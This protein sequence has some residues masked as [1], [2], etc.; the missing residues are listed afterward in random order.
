MDNGRNQR[1][2][3]PGGVRPTGQVEIAAAERRRPSITS[4]L[5]TSI[6]AICLLVGPSAPAQGAVFGG[7][8]RKPYEKA[9]PAERA[10]LLNAIG[11]ISCF[12]G[13][14]GSGFLVDITEYV[15][16][17]PNFYVIA[18]TAQVLYDEAG[19][20]RGRC[21]YVPASAPGHYFEI[22]D[23]LAGTTR[24][25]GADSDN[26]AFARIEHLSGPHV[27]LRIAF[28]NTYDFGP[29]YHLELEVAGFV[30]AWGEVAVTSECSL[31][32]KSRYPALWKQGFGLAHM[33]IHDC[34]FMRSARGG[35]L[36]IRDRG[37][38]LVIAVNAGDTRSE[39]QTRLYGVPYDPQRG[40]YN[41]SRRFDKELEQRL[42]AFVSRFAPVKHPSLAMQAQSELVR[43]VQSNLNRIGY[44]AGTVDGV[45]GRKTRE[46]IQAFQVTLGITP[47]G[48]VSEELLL[49][50]RSK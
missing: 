1:G 23:R 11:G 19:N 50:L 17:E 25:K 7:D 38:L 3:E 45:L 2:E 8:D 26:W 48:R 5:V 14:W 44:D 4:R 6:W 21:A 43:E 20:V 30:E 29:S 28:G 46:A 24:P 49:L 22:G 40:F 42:I 27:P 36:S 18:T 16:G 34:D 12:D 31:D 15:E 9:S 37:E 39:K 13:T 41:F 33:I 32:D 47:T 10:T 35:P